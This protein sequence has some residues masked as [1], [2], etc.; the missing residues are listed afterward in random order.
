MCFFNKHLFMKNK[1]RV[2][3]L[4]SIIAG[5]S[6]ASYL[7]DWSNDDLCGWMDSASAPEYIQIEVEKREILC[8]GGTEVS[9]LPAEA[10]LSSED[11]T[12]FPS[13]DPAL[14]PEIKPDKNKSYSY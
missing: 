3:F 11:G 14:I 7:D 5:A 4:L 13:P 1:L 6:N 10:N 9:S 2:F 12:V 8:H